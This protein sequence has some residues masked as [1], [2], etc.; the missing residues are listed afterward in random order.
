MSAL[1]IEDG[2]TLTKTLDAAPGIHPAVDV[3]YRPAL[4]RA[5]KAYFAAT[6]NT[7]D[8]DKIDAAEFDLLTKHVVALDGG[9]FPG[10]DRFP[11]LHPAVRGR[12][13]DLV[14]SLEAGD[15]PPETSLGN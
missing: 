9:A 5:R 14:L 13:L 2:F 7:R 11:R 12:L 8:L 10:K 15:V 6:T 1:Y 3:V 4:D